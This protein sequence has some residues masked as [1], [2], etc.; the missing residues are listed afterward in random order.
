MESSLIEILIL[1][2]VLYLLA[3][4]IKI[5]GQIT[6]MKHTLNQLSKGMNIPESPIDPEIKKLIEEGND[7]KAIKRARELFGFT[8]L[9]GKK[10]VEAM[11]TEHKLDSK[12]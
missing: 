7:V 10:Y 12:L 5:S 4:V 11:K 2:L 1:V 8:L 6:G 3:I 9:E